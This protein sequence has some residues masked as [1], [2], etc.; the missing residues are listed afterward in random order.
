MESEYS[1]AVLQYHSG[2]YEHALRIIQT[3]LKDAPGTTELLELKALNLK[4]QQKFREAIEVYRELARNERKAGKNM[5][6]IAPYV[7]ELGVLYFQ[8]KDYRR[9][10]SFF[11]MAA[12][13]AF[14]LEASELYLGQVLSQQGNYSEAEEHFVRAMNSQIFEIRAA[15]SF[16]LGDLQFRRGYSVGGVQSFTTAA[17]AAQAVIN[18]PN[19][20][21]E[22]KKMAQEILRS[23]RDV[24]GSL[25]RDQWFGNVGFLFGYDSNVLTLP[26][27]T[28]TNQASGKKALKN[29]L[30]WGAGYSTS[31]VNT[32]QWVPSYRGSLNINFNNSSKSAE[33]ASHTLSLYINKD[34]LKSFTY[35]L[36]AEGV[37]T[38]QNQALTNETR[39]KFK[40][41]S[42]V[43]QFGPY[44]KYTFPSQWAIS[45][46]FYV[47]PQSYKIDS[48]NVESQR[49]TG[50]L[51]NAGLAFEKNQNQG[52][53][54]PEI[55]G[56]WS[57][58]NTKGTENRAKTYSLGFANSLYL[59]DRMKA[60]PG[61][62]FALAKY[63]DRVPTTRTDKI[64][65]LSVAVTY[66]WSKRLTILGDL[67]HTW[68][69][70]DIADSYTY[71]RYEITTGLSYSI[72]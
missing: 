16:A 6:A 71:Q 9:A 21:P 31:P 47:G 13:S 33:F 64:I 39:F 48:Q 65:T 53:F 58:E 8:E 61:V 59:S 34:A 7:Y 1:E 43:T 55:A 68:N 56:A 41:Y 66:A 12:D 52:F 11:R 45:A 62:D 67:R 5:L 3:L 17:D 26:S 69:I 60:L 22:S 29:T 46:D 32:I 10:E 27:S 50:T 36:K 4:N 2:N 51:W 37:Y 20:S 28:P 70:S 40:P 57:Y 44:T 23:A 72:F 18:N 25:D 30:L 19:S 35:G 63:S 54:N 42:F 38:M 24:L 15:S 14:N 49:R